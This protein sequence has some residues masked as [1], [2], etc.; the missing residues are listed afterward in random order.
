MKIIRLSL[1]VLFL[2]LPV[3][4]V[5]SQHYFFTNYTIDNGLSNNSVRCIAKDKEGFLW[6]GTDAGLNRFNG[7][8]FTV[9]KC[10]ASDS[11]ALPSSQI[12][13]LLVDNSGDL[14]IST[15]Q[16]I[17]RYN[18]N[19]NNFQRMY[20][21]TKGGRQVLDQESSDIYQDSKKNIWAVAGIYNLVKY[22]AKQ[23]CFEEVLERLPELERNGIFSITEDADATLWLSGYNHLLHY[24]PGNHRYTVFENQ[25]SATGESFQA[26]KVFPDSSD[27]N[28]LWIATWGNGLVHFDKHS[29]RFD[30]YRF[31]E[32]LPKNLS[33][34]I[35]DA[36]WNKPNELWLATNQGIVVFDAGKKIFEGFIRD[37][38]NEKKIA[39]A[40]SMCISRDDEGILWIGT[41]DGICNIHP[42]KQNFVAQPLWINPTVSG[43]FCEEDIDKIYGLR[44]YTNRALI[45]YDRKTGGQT[46]FKIPGAD[47][48]K[49]EPFSVLKDNN[50]LL[51]IG[52]TKGI[53][54]F[55]E[56]GKKFA[57]FPAE[58]KLGT[59]DRSLFI[60]GSFK[61]SE[62]NLWFPS[63]SKGLVRI[64]PMSGNAQAYFHHTEDAVSFPLYAITGITEGKEKKLYACDERSGVV[65]MNLEGKVID[66]FNPGEKKYSVLTGATD[67]AA[68]RDGRIW[69]TTRT[70]G[71][72]C[73]DPDHK[74][75]AFVKDD[76]GNILD[77]L[78]SL[79]IDH[80][81]KIWSTASHGIYCFDP[82]T[83]KFSRFTTQDG[84]PVHTL[85]DPLY[86]LS[87]GRIAYSFS[88]G[89][90]C[91][92][93]S[94][95]SKNTKP[96]SVHLTSLS[97][98]GK[99][100]E[101]NSFIDRLDTILLDHSENN[102]TFE[103]AA[104]DF[105]NPLSDLYSYMLE[106]MN[107]QWSVPGKTRILNFSQ[108][109][110]GNFML[111]IKAGSNSPEKKIGIY[112]VPAWWQTV[113]F[114][115]AFAVAVIAGLFFTIRFFISLRYR[116]QIAKLEQEREIENMRSRISRDIHDEI[117]SGLTKIKLMSRNLLKVKEE[118]MMKET[119]A[120]I[121][122]ASDERIQNLGEIVWTINPANDSLENMVAFIRSYV[123]RL[124]DENPDVKLHLDLPEPSQISETSINPEI[125]RNLVLILK[126]ALTNIFRHA[127]ATEVYVTL[128]PGKPGLRLSIRDNGIGFTPKQQN[129]SGN[130]I[131]N[132]KKRA[133]VI[134]AAF[135]IDSE[136]KKGTTINLVIPL[137][138][139]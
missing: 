88:K 128:Q 93:P 4:A 60:K 102:L 107:R 5:F 32:N 78:L 3:H 37:S 11:T 133:S 54:T 97:V 130:G 16:G 138:D 106:G 94:L 125:K 99:M 56:Q 8:D 10:L 55:N 21:C 111:H 89:I 26:M 44:I 46:E 135:T 48:F 84:L 14:W 82:V 80:A 101:Y 52:T 104:T 67:I 47:Q 95:V 22:N 129:G 103:F 45:I 70:N 25:L 119:T 108:L 64:D 40:E 15:M 74:V 69:V 24:N 17:C 42:S 63:Y 79:V 59:P 72:I 124:F 75:T 110:P 1:L 126:E 29:A 7:Y 83:N 105:A 116:E 121:S 65:R 58:Q 87:D 35:F 13:H 81:G 109:P 98:N 51:W 91:F 9:Y 33:N 61:D 90:F 68:D 6:I 136:I 96:L 77:E 23:N 100:P 57:M 71:L 19:R 53:Y 86:K 127:E 132:M 62:G 122:S 137:A 92:N 112:I 114:R 76:F 73:I 27:N 20:I 18:K 41:S 85:S 139:K 113:L 28:F 66:W 115:W 117:G 134:N 38:I 39:N 36:Y 31:Q 120:K 43:Y 118:A 30:A 49:A 34:I 12:R 131:N 123:S 50:G 2:Q